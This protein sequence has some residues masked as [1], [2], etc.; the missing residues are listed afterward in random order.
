LE[1][2]LA[3]ERDG[4]KRCFGSKDATEGMMAFMQKRKPVFNQG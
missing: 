2:L 3:K 4:V 1:E